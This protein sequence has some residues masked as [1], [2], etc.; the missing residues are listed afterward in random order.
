MGRKFSAIGLRT[1]DQIEVFATQ[2]VTCRP[3]ADLWQTF[4]AKED[5]R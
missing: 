2:G 1:I 3:A 5:E 4:F